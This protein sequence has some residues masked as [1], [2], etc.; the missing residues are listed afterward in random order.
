MAK[1]VLQ[2]ST[3][4]KWFYGSEDDIYPGVVG[5]DV[6]LKCRHNEYAD[7]NTVWDGFVTA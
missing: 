5:Y 3:G 1:H 6:L 4:N 7:A 2:T